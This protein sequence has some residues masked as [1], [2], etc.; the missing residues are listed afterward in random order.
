MTDIVERLR[1]DHDNNWEDEAADEIER[2]RRMRSEWRDIAN[3]NLTSLQQATFRIA[4]AQ[5][6]EAKLR[7]A[8]EDYFNQYP[9]MMKGYIVDALAIPSDD[10][11]FREAIQ[12][13]RGPLQNRL[14]ECIGTLQATFRN[15]KREALLEAAEYVGRNVYDT[16]EYAE[17]LRRMAEELK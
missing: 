3:T 10:T 12:A 13:A 1:N 17:R 9:Y 2:L 4:E 5:A 15:A 8:M 7:E 14:D 16:R 11:V 6:R